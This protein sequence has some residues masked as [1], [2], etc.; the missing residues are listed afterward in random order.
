MKSNTVKIKPFL[1]FL[2]GVYL[3]GVLNECLVRVKKGKGT[4]EA[5][6]ITNSTIIVGEKK[7]LSGDIN[8]DFGLGN[9]ELLIK[10]LSS[11]Q[12]ESVSFKQKGNYLLFGVKSKKSHKKLEYLLTQP[13]LIA[14]RFNLSQNEKGKNKNPI[15]KILESLE[16]S[17]SFPASFI[18]D[19]CSYMSL[20]KNQVTNGIVSILCDEDGEIEFVYGEKNDHMLKLSL[21]S[22]MDEGED[23]EIKINGEHLAKIF[24]A[25]EYSQDDQP[26]IHFSNNQPVVVKAGKMGWALVPIT[27]LEE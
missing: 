2:E 9:I 14:T 22:E 12:D 13:D 26:T 24:M 8:A 15:N 23:L 3:G 10:F 5:I 27:D 16:Y 7:I 18:K 21:D 19:H 1:H 20:L 25:I 11:A 6:D 17:T 4:V